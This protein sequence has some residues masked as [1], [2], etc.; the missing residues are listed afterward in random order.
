V[1]QSTDTRPTWR[2]MKSDDLQESSGSYPL[3]MAGLRELSRV[4][5]AAARGGARGALIMRAWYRLA[6]QAF[7]AARFDAATP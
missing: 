3:T 7:R 2:S 4:C 1:C 6:Y 5:K